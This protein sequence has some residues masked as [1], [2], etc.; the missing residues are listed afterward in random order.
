MFVLLIVPAPLLGGEAEEPFRDEAR[1]ALFT[2]SSGLAPHRV[3][4][5]VETD[6]GLVWAVAGTRLT[7]FDGYEWKPVPSAQALAGPIANLVA[8]GRRVCFTSDSQ[9]YC[10]DLS[11]F[12]RVTQPP[13]ADAAVSV[14]APLGPDDLAVLVTDGRLFRVHARGVEEDA[15]WPGANLGVKTLIPTSPGALIRTDRGLWG[16]SDGSWKPLRLPLPSIPSVR[17]ATACGP[18]AGLMLVEHPRSARGLWSWNREGRVSRAEQVPSLLSVFACSTTGTAI[19]FSPDGRVMWRSG[20]QWRQLRELPQKT[21]EVNFAAFRPNG[22]LWVGAEGGLL[23]H[24]AGLARWMGTRWPLGDSRNFVSELMRASDGTLW[25]GSEAGITAISRDGS[26]RAER[27]FPGGTEHIVTA[28]GEDPANRIW[29]GC[30]DGFKGV[31]IRDAGRW[32]RHVT[33]T[34]LDDLNVHRIRRDRTGRLWFLTLGES[35]PNLPVSRGPRVFVLAGGQVRPWPPAGGLDGTRIYEM[36]E[37]PDGALWFATMAGVERWQGGTWRKWS[38]RDGLTLPRVFA[39]A[40]SPSGDAYFGDQATGLSVID[41]DRV[42]HL[43]TADG[44]ISDA[45]QALAFAPRGALWITTQAGVSRYQDGMFANVG[46]GLGAPAG[47]LWPILVEDEG[48]LVG[49]SGSGIARL[50]IDAPPERAPTVRVVGLDVSED[51]AHVRW[52]A[53]AYWGEVPPDQVM[54]RTRLDDHPWSGWSGERQVL[55]KALATG[56]HVFSVQAAHPLWQGVSSTTSAAIVIAPPWFAAPRFYLPLAL[57]AGTIVGLLFTMRARARRQ[58]RVARL[59]E[60][61]RQESRH[62]ESLGRLA[63]GVAHDFN[64]LL[65]VIGGNAQLAGEDP[66]LGAGT[67][68]AL[69]DV[70]AAVDQAARLTRHLLA[71][72][73]RQPVAPQPSDINAL[74]QDT[75]PLLV[76]VVGEPIAIHHRLSRDTIVAHV[77]RGQFESVLVNL[78][79]NARDAMPDGGTLTIET[80]SVLVEAP[81]RAGTHEKGARPYATVSFAD[82]GA[83]IT[84]EAQPHIFEPFFTTKGPGRGTGL[85]LASCYGSVTQAGGFIRVSSVPGQ[86][87]TFTVHLPRVTAAPVERRAAENKTHQPPPPA[88][89]AGGHE[90]VLVVEDRADVR[91]TISQLLAR[92]GYVVLEAVNGADALAVIESEPV[93]PALVITDVVMPVMTGPELAAELHTRHPTIKILFVSGFASALPPELLNSERSGGLL[94]KPYAPGQLLERVAALLG[95]RP[96][97]S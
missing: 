26:V 41:H 52:T 9:L 61:E 55:V 89:P 90:R 57:L 14:T 23:L 28:L 76:R 49:S 2:A 1:W 43:T 10:G 44:L 73:R 3:V 18:D 67:R 11:G 83:G 20:S 34:P 97:S 72:A 33:G 79:A 95:A 60:V 59:V 71:F 15:T 30:G 94:M 39:I 77:D 48:I 47:R 93:P 64:N 12:T 92:N 16:W 56:N 63:G 40:V 69:R 46:R 75:L 4:A 6:D 35:D 96:G 80:G 84:P 66:S 65:T 22:D 91:R 82:T 45:I 62:L 29:A 31:F 19:V 85:G 27:L 50:S 13:L 42:R 87:A 21:S 38:T 58:A 81:E 25:I 68:A 8:Q 36:S 51:T 54:T 86:G 24:R 32:S 37:G 70:E 7:H 17:M 78:A 88:R 74:V 53:L 5:L